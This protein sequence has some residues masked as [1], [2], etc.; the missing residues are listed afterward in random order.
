MNLNHSEPEATGKTSALAQL[1]NLFVAPGQALD[2]AREKP[3]MWWLPLGIVLVLQAVMGVWV[4]MTMNMAAW[5]QMMVETVSRANPEHAQQAIQM[6]TQHG[7]GYLLFGMLVGVVFMVIVELLYALYL[8]LAD[9]LFSADNRGFGQWF[10]F[11]TWTWL[12]ISLGLIA[13]I[14]AWALS[15]KSGHFDQLDV[16]NLNTLFFH[17]KPGSH[18]FRVAQFSVLQFWVIGLATYGLKRWRGHGTGK[19]LAIAIAPY[20]VIYAIMYFV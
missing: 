1:V 9:K 17:F 16:T 8:F 20:V 14:I 10:S 3:G 19:A 6:I 11:T 15:N 4:A 7:R 18:L 5:R 13:S 2:Y 12:P